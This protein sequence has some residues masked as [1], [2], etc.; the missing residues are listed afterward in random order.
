M[1]TQALGIVF[2]LSLGLI[3]LY[4]PLVT[5]TS[6]LNRVSDLAARFPWLDWLT[7]LPKTVISIIQG[8]L[9]PALL[10]LILLLVPIIFRF[11][12]HHQGVS[13]GNNK[14]LGVQFWVFAFLFIQVFLIATISGGMSLTTTLITPKSGNISALTSTHRSAPN[15]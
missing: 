4:A 13:T 10:S 11:F 9:P 1:L 6:L 3:V 2:A 5:F 7:R 15:C 14:E 12:V 8:V